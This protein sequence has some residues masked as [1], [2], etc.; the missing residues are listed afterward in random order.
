[1][2]SCSIAWVR[3]LRFELDLEKLAQEVT[4][5]A[6]T[7]VGAEVGAYFR[8]FMSGK[9]EAYVLSAL[10]GLPREAFSGFLPS[11][12]RDLFGATFQEGVLR[13]DDMTLDPGFDNHPFE[14]GMPEGRP[15]VHSYLAVPVGVRSGEVLGGLI[16]GHSVPGKF[17]EN[18]EAILIGIAAHAGVAMDNASLFEQSQWAQAELK[19]SNEELRRA[20]CDLEVFAYSASHDLQEPLRTIALS[21]QLI[22]RNWRTQPAGEEGT[23]L[24]NIL[25]ATRRMSALLEDLLAYTKATKYEEG[26][27][28]LVDSGRVLDEVLET[29]RG[30]IADTGA[31]VTSGPLPAVAIHGTRLAQLFQNLITNATKYRRKEIP[32]VHV[33]AEQ[34][35]GWCIFSVSDNGIGIEP[36][37][38]EQIFGLFKRLHGR[39]EYPGS[40]IGLAICQRVVEQYGGRIWL[41]Q[42]TAGRGSTFCF[43]IPSRP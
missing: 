20:N 15:S 12:Y 16:F 3:A 5:I 25:N 19:R 35:D 22:Q 7:L 38:A 42:S 41:E 4:D 30:Q 24:V 43:S 39:D 33:G 37:F 40:G 11:Q 6:A 8:K 26:P 29:L 18:D 9:E 36:Q 27:A 1:M 21:A 34:R 13:C 10:S 2:R 32:H 31:T 28:P 14:G 23:L 17:T